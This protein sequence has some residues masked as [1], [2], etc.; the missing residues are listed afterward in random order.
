MVGLHI[1]NG[2]TVCAACSAWVTMACWQQ[3]KLVDREGNSQS[4]YMFAMAQPRHGL[5]MA[6]L[7]I[8]VKRCH[9]VL[10]NSPCSSAAAL[11]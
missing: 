9:E 7:R 8:C 6:Q 10:A 3:T 1:M 2:L 11:Q 5:L 4:G